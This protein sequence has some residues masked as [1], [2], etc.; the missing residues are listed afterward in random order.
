MFTAEDHALVGAR[1]PNW[2]HCGSSKAAYSVPV[3]PIRGN[4]LYT[5]ETYDWPIHRN[6]QHQLAADDRCPG[7]KNL[8]QIQD[9]QVITSKQYT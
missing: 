6:K 3:G 1:K 4:V 7:I 9:E 5:E 2:S 8:K